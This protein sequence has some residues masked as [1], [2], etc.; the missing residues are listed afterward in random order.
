MLN[1]QFGIKQSTVDKIDNDKFN[2]Q[3]HI[4]KD[5]NKTN[6]IPYSTQDTEEALKQPPFTKC[7]SLSIH[8]EVLALNQ[9]LCSGQI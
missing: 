4:I 2:L 3:Y 9:T 7:S 8:S 1:I 5:K 6:V